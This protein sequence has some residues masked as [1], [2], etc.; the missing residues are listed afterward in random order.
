MT[1]PPACVRYNDWRRIEPASP[2]RFRPAFP[3]SV[4]VPYH[5][6][7]RALALTLA[8]LEVQTWP[9]ELF[10]VVIVD[11][12]SDPPLKRPATP[13]PV[14]VARQERR[15]FALARARNTGAR[16]A[17]HD[18]LL[19]LDGDM[20]PEAGW[21][22]A[23]ARWHHAAADVLT[24]GF[25]AYVGMDGVR[26]ETI[27]DRP[28]SLQ[29]LFAGRPADPSLA[30]PHLARTRDLTSK[31]D[32][33][34]RVMVGANFG[35]RRELYEAAGG[36]D[37]SFTSYGSED[38]EFAYR[39]YTRGA[40][41]IPAR[42]AFA[43]HQGR[44]A[45]D[46]ERKDALVRLQRAKIAHLV[47]H[48]EF[49]DARPGRFFQVPQYVVTIE[50]ACLPENRVVSLTETIL[51][52]RAHD[53]VVRIDLPEDDARLPGLRRQFD[54]DPRVR[55]A[56]ALPA[57]D[58][59]PAA[60]F[61][62]TVPSGAVFARGLVRR[63]RGEIGVAAAAAAV[64]P[65]GSRVSIVRAWALHRARRTGREVAEFGDAVTIPARRL[66][67]GSARP[68]GARGQE[69]RRRLRDLHVRTGRIRTLRQA[70]QLLEQLAGASRWWLTR[71]RLA[72][73][74]PVS[75]HHHHHHPPPPVTTRLAPRM[76]LPYRIFSDAAIRRHHSCRASTGGADHPG[77]RAGAGRPAA[78]FG[79]GNP[80][81]C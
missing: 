9:R 56:P 11:D 51:A 43:W 16:T 29:E 80:D 53:L 5:E 13:L 41:L 14:T 36:F 2:G 47:A 12:G 1:P 28:G 35:I 62:V 72:R 6:A 64:L 3:V 27:R 32:D 74:A 68:D 76:E 7:P 63:L 21:I 67:I 34:F 79:R 37:E 23:H 46:R 58:E 81:P 44:W 66:R 42:E 25:R 24:L 4:I 55:V 59:F 40:V 75:V 30:E 45:D 50:P 22:A 48:H 18:I 49:R 26:P 61:H 10:E 17:A 73:C 78:R 65:D 38:V 54:P 31:A 71:R 60:P 33:L 20:L 77:R 70:W 57:L 15:G 69:L 19:F 52:D 39:V 8:A